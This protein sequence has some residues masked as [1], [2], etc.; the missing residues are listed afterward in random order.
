[1][2]ESRKRLEFSKILFR[3]VKLAVRFSK[4]YIYRIRIS[5]KGIR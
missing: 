3:H 2:K 5:Y 4:V 1:L